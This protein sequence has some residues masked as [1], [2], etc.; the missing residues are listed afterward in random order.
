MRVD[1]QRLIRLAVLI[2]QRSFRL[3]ADQLG[4]SQPALSQSIAQMEIE[5]GVK[6]I[7]RTPHGVEPTLYG[8]ALYRHA[9]AIDH[10]LAQ[11]ARDIQELTFGHK[12][13]L[14]VGVT[15]GAAASLVATSLCSFLQLHPGTGIKVIEDTSIQSL[16]GRLQERDVDMLMCQQPH[17]IALKGARAISL[18]RAKQVA[19][20]RAGHPLRGK[21]TL[22]DLAKYPFVCPPDEL[23]QVF[24]FRKLFSMMGLSLPEVLVSNSIH[25]SKTIVVNSDSFALFSELFAA[26]DPDLHVVELVEPELPEYWMQLIV[27]EEQAASALMQD[28]VAEIVKVCLSMGLEPHRDAIKFPRSTSAPFSSQITESIPPA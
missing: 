27:R 28:F 8:K 3:A 1:P 14:A 21:A 26:A 13:S 11:A 19:C 12:G 2:E 16:L 9:R 18:F 22:T 23:G 6:L 10:E 7:E 4:V 25:I 24:G 17:D 15:A 5:V 20:V